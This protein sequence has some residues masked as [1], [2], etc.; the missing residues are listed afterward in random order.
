MHPFKFFNPEAEI[1][2]ARGHLPHWDQAGTTTFI[3][4][5]TADSV[6]REIWVKWRAERNDWLQAHGIDPAQ[7]DWRRMV[8]VLPQGER[9]EFRR[10]SKRLE[11]EL[12]LG[13]G[14]CVFRRPELRDI[15]AGALHHFDG[16]RYVLGDFV[17][18]PNHVHLLV[19]GLARA[20]LLMQVESWKKWSALQL[21]P[22]LG[23]KGRFWQDESYDHLVRSEEA[24]QR[25]KKYIAEN[26]VKAGLREGEY[27]HWEYGSKGGPH[28]PL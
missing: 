17:I 11:E 13:H 15:L 28:S 22:R 10:F 6:P 5:R 3:T 1:V 4:W 23:R 9:T 7:P 20:A 25:F 16:L 21:N 12:D 27:S 2:V 8:E 14:A 26:P 18:M 24:F 19:G